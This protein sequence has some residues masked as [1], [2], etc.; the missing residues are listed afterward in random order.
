MTIYQQIAFTIVTVFLECLL[1]TLRQSTEE[2]SANALFAAHK[3]APFVGPAV[4]SS[5]VVFP[6]V[7]MFIRLLAFILS[8][9]LIAKV[10][11][12]ELLSKTG[13]N[14]QQRKSRSAQHSG[15]NLEEPENALK[16]FVAAINPVYVVIL[17]LFI[18]A[19]CAFELAYGSRKAPP[20]TNLTH[21]ASR[22]APYS[23]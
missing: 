16:E 20:R 15:Q 13:N 4:S 1:C 10:F 14:Q 8:T 19:G 12:D 11:A 23:A 5:A 21:V 18:L 9:C 6:P 7:P 22:H 17:G 2:K 3:K